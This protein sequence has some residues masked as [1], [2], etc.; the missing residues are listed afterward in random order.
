[1]VTGNVIRQEIC[2]VR[3]QSHEPP[4]LLI[5]GGS[6][7]AMFLNE[8]VPKACAKLADKGACFQVIHVVGAGEGRIEAAQ[9]I[10]RGAGIPAEVISFS[11]DMPSLFARASLMVARAGAM[12]VGEAAA[13]GM[14][15]LF[16][17]LPW[18]ADNHQ[19]HNARVMEE[20]GAAMI[21]NQH[22]C[23]E[24][25][26]ALKLDKTLCR[27]STLARMHRAARRTFIRNAK[28]L[29]LQVLAEYLGEV[30]T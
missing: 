15:C 24:A 12:T 27:P 30:R 6:Q 26:L 2:A 21:L 20:A 29:Q 5:V 23:D 13:V 7:G 10:Y 18:A 25:L 19:Y 16:V 22:T 4:C 17:P 14:P 9:A 1:V 11:D 3:Y 28:V 8:T